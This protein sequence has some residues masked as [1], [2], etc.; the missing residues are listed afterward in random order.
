MDVVNENTAKKFKLENIELKTTVSRFS[1]FGST[2]GQQML[3]NNT[4]KSVGE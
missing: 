1:H 2:Q 3:E 4:V